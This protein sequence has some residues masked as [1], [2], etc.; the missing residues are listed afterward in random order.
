M[1]ISPGAL[2]WAWLTVAGRIT[3]AA[4]P[5]IVAHSNFSHAPTL[6]TVAAIGN[7]VP[8]PLQLGKLP[9]PR[10]LAWVVGPASATG[11]R[12]R[13]G[14]VEGIRGQQRA[15]NRAARCQFVT[16]G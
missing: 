6:S 3:T 12:R 4:F 14:H 7:H 15:R 11:L 16:G 10:D 9:P 13:E 8:P 5:G 2:L 1:G